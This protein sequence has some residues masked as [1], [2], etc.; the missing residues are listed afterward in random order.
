MREIGGYIEMN[1]GRGIEYHKNAIALNSGRSCVEYLIRAKKIKKL[2]IPYF[3]CSSIRGLCEKCRCEYELYNILSDFMPDLKVIPKEN[4]YMLVINYYGQITEK[5]IAEIKAK[6]KNIILDNTQDFFRMPQD[7]TDTI[8]SCRKFFGIP[9]GA[10]LYTDSFIDDEIETDV[11]YDKM[12][13]LMGRL[14]LGAEKFYPEYVEN[15]SKFSKENIKYMSVLTHT[16]LGNEDYDFVKSRRTE[17]FEFLHSKL[18]GKNKLKLMVPNGPFM[19]PL[20]LENGESVKRKLI[21][22]K[23]FVP[24]LWGA[25][26]DVSKPDSIESYYSKNIV[27]LPIDQRYAIEEMKYILEVLN[28]VLSER[29]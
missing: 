18:E 8:Y 29:N 20:L 16:L 7:N 2:Y 15:N 13:F 21:E 3:L 5:A 17:N 27:P 19:Y 12:R 14:E 26:F 9:D 23:I 10:Y 28:N 4:E 25:V 1:R 6:Y 22:K 11:S 24:T